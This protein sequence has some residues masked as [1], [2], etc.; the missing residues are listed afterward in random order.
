MRWL[1][2]TLGLEQVQGCVSPNVRT[3]EFKINPVKHTLAFGA[4]AVLLLS[5][6]CGGGSGGGTTPPP[7]SPN[8]APAII[9]ISPSSATAGGAAF[10]LTLTGQNFVSSSTVEW[11]GNPVTT[12]F[13]SDSRL[14]AQIAAAE[15]ANS[16]TAAVSVTNPLP[17][18]GNSGSAEF[19]INPASN[20][21][22]SVVTLSPSLVNAGSPGFLLTVN[23]NN[24]M[25]VSTILWN[26]TALPT[27]FLSDGQLEAQ[28]PASNLASSGFVEITVTNPAPGGGASTP[29]IFTVAYVPTV[30]SQLA[31][32]LVWDGTHQL[33]YLSV[34]SLGGALDDYLLGKN[35]R[36]QYLPITPSRM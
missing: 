9:S 30:V 5:A 4:F 25:H 3:R 29:A 31:N 36:P 32:D 15:I 16:G 24:F 28:I 7:P 34:P 22:P 27:N 1:I 18:G 12:T 19:T 33:I 6:G 2:A 20:P 8:P 26:G 35:T 11:N 14:Q 13:S 21:A 10:T 17:G 23:G